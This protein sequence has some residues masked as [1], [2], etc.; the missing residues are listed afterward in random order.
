MGTDGYAEAG[1]DGHP[2]S[3]RTYADADSDARGPGGKRTEDRH[4]RGPSGPGNSE[5][6]PVG[7]GSDETKAKV[8][9][10]T[11]GNASGLNEYD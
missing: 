4:R 3:V 9:S 7:P 1:G 5:Q 11:H 8:S 6:E 10:G 2:G